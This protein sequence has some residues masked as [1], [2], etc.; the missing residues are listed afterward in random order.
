VDLYTLIL[1]LLLSFL[2]NCPSCL[3]APVP[4]PA[5][6]SPAPFGLDRAV[7]FRLASSWGN[8]YRNDSDVKF[9]YGRFSIL[10]IGRIWQ[11]YSPDLALETSPIQTLLSPPVPSAAVFY[12]SRIR[13]CRTSSRANALTPSRIV[14]CRKRKRSPKR[15]HGTYSST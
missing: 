5:S 4:A 15:Q 6:E 12:V 1:L 14:N 7:L 10:P 13:K 2:G 11:Q 8:N 3:A 9:L